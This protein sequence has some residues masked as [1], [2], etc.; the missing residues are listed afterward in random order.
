MSH[1]RADPVVVVGGG[2]AGVEAAFALRERGHDEPLILVSDEPE[3]PYR[4]GEL[5]GRY[6]RG[7]VGSDAIRLAPLEAYRRAGI[8]LLL[9]ARATALRPAARRLAIRGHGHLR[10]RRAIIA[11]GSVLVDGIPGPPPFRVRTRPEADELRAASRPGGRAI[12]VGAGPLGR[13]VAS[14]LRWLGMEVLVLDERDT[15]PDGSDPGLPQL[16]RQG[17]VVRMRSQVVEFGG[18]ERATAVRTA[19]GA[20]WQAELVVAATG[21][22]PADQLLVAAG[23]EVRGRLAGSGALHRTSDPFVLVTGDVARHE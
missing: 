4:R 9:G 13:D 3:L 12:V 20:R 10:Y 14:S 22:R 16:E 8:D 6:L 11:T 2:A 7:E 19:H 1:G 15:L 18:H 17:V 21:T 5:P 23:I